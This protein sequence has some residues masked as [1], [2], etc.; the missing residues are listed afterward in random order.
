MEE[1]PR[2]EGDHT[3][4]GRP[5]RL[6]GRASGDGDPSGQWHHLPAR[7]GGF[8][9]HA[10]SPAANLREIATQPGGTYHHAADATQ[11][12]DVL[13]NHSDALREVRIDAIDNSGML[14]DLT[15][16]VAGT[17]GEFDGRL[18]PSRC[19]TDH[20]DCLTSF[21]PVL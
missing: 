11:L 5:E 3:A 4:G 12:A 8:P 17:A 21:P 14:R 15:L 16:S 20:P 10:N 1:A 6:R 7:D 18:R 2:F 13:I 9:Y 19:G